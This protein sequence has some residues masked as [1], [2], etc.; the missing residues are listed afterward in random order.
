MNSGNGGGRLTG[1]TRRRFMVHSAA[2]LGAWRA[3]WAQAPQP[4]NPPPLQPPSGA[5][6]SSTVNVVNVFATVRDNKGAIVHNLTRDDFTLLEDDR[7]QTIRYFS[8]ESDLPL[9]LGLL[10]DTSMSQ[11]RLI[12]PERKASY[13]FFQQVLREDKDAAFIIHFD[14]EA[15]LLQDLTGS[16]KKLQA[17]L[18]SLDTPPAQRF[19]GLGR[20][21]GAYPPAPPGTP[22]GPGGGGGGRRGGGTVLYDAALLASHELMARQI[23][24]KALILL[25]DGVDTGSR[26]TLDDAVEAATR[27]DTLVYSIL[28]ADPDVYVRPGPPPG[29][30]RRR[31]GHPPPRQSP[32]DGKKVLQMISRQTG[33]AFYEV[34]RKRPI[35]WVYAA[36]EEDL[37]HQYS[38]GYT[39]DG[40]EGKTFRRIR[41]A[42]NNRRLV[43]RTREG[44]YPR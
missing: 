12:E 19:G 24:R 11:R 36:I 38:L 26:V 27:A 16:R 23:G 21:G 32:A 4:S 18:E 10:V 15:E 7:P 2:A 31:P 29:R 37:R 14:F 1:S 20:R 8:Q 22:P 6:Y 13:S 44:Y 30:G 9:T 40:S 5:S 34:S 17:A 33:G 35:E 43:V 28:F 25:T 41:L 3:L 39:S 42:A